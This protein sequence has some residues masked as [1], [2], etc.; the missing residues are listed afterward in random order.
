MVVP[1][2]TGKRLR[3]FCERI[4]AH[5]LLVTEA[6]ISCL[7]YHPRLLRSRRPILR[8]ATSRL[9]GVRVGGRGCALP[10][11]TRQELANDRIRERTRR[12]Q[13]RE[14]N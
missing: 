12:A 10:P 14:L 6:S 9:M 13:V 4:S 8:R 11:H 7:K 3:K 5:G 1:W 2:L